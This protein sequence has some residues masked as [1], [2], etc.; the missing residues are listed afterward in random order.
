LVIRS[1]SVVGPSI[2]WGESF[3]DWILNK[4]R[5]GNSIQLFEDQY[6]SPIHIRSM[7]DVLEEVCIRDVVGLLHVGG[8]RRLSRTDIGYTIVRAYGLN[9]DPIEPVSYKTHPDSAIM[10]QDTSFDGSRLRQT[11][12]AVRLKSLDEEFLQDAKESEVSK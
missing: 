6:R 7:T 12:P 11:L 10:P 2:G 4:L 5:F 3:S 9:P 8:L 1:N